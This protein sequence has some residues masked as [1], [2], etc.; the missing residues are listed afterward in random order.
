[1]W[2]RFNGCVAICCCA[3]RRNFFSLCANID[4]RFIARHGSCWLGR[5]LDEPKHILFAPLTGLDTRRNA[6]RVQLIFPK[7]DLDWQSLDSAQFSGW[8][9]VNVQ[10]F[11]FSLLPIYS[12]TY[13]FLR[14][15]FVFYQ[16]I[17]AAVGHTKRKSDAIHPPV[18][19]RE[20]ENQITNVAPPPLVDSHGDYGIC[21]LVGNE[22]LYVAPLH[23]R[24]M[25]NL[26]LE[27]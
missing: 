7:M 24:R 16:S 10:R 5:R 1:M 4:R 6:H 12:F 22:R 14:I 19:R 15:L 27:F 18:W 11:S 23:S 17:L 26:L 8:N 2:D 13:S 20:Y 21:L 9:S 3:L 25:W